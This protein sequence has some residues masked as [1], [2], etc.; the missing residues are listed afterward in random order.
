MTENP[1]DSIKTK[2]NFKLTTRFNKVVGYK[3]QLH[4]CVFTT[5]HLKMQLGEK[6][7]LKYYKRNKT[8][9]NKLENY[10]H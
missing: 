5:K 3:N 7:Y 4:F 1:K 10:K 6:P 8:L 9:R 2:T